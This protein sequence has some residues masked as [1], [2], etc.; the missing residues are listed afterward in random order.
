M[1]IYYTFIPISYIPFLYCMVESICTTTINKYN[2]H[3]KTLSI[4]SL[5]LS[6]SLY[7][8]YILSL[9]LLYVP[10]ATKQIT[11]LWTIRLDDDDGEDDVDGGGGGGC[12]TVGA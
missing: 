10:S 11:W 8:P 5:S 9:S 12:I 3:P 1:Y 4:L 6:L 2:P 7:S